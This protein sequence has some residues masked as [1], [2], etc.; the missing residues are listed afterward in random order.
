MLLRNKYS[1]RYGFQILGT[2]LLD[3]RNN[4]PLL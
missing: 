2:W 1:N 4:S 3:G